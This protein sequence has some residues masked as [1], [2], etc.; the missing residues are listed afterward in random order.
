MLPN[1][2]SLAAMLFHIY[3]SNFPLCWEDHW[4]LHTVIVI[5]DISHSALLS[6]WS[7]LNLFQ[8]KRSYKNHIV[9]SQ[10]VDCRKSH[11]HLQSSSS[12]LIFPITWNLHEMKYTTHLL[13]VL[14]F[15]V[16]APYADL[17]FPGEKVYI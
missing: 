13:H 7:I 11:L 10:I 8:N 2:T 9:T 14:F 12:N 1:T 4:W 5:S 16:S 6:I 3:S 17:F 15:Q